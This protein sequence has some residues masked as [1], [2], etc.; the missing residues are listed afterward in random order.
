MNPGG[1]KVE[2]AHTTD[3]RSL[4]GMR[5]AAA[6]QTSS[7][8]PD[9]GESAPLITPKQYIISQCISQQIQLMN[10]LIAQPPPPFGR[11][12]IKEASSDEMDIPL[13]FRGPRL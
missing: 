5:R 7:H 11:L 10:K 8:R 1:L 3:P 12:K 13:R 2:I 6:A 9:A 4:G